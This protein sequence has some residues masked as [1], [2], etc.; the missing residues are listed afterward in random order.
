MAAGSKLAFGVFASSSLAGVLTLGVGPK[1]AHR[2]VRDAGPD[3]CLTLTR[4][5]LDDQLPRNAASRVLGLVIRAL[6]RHT[7]LRFVLSY[8]DPAAGH[9]GTVYQATGW[10]YTGLSEGTPLYDLG[11][12]IPRHSRSLGHAYGTRS[13]AYLHA[14]GIDV[15]LVAQ[16]R[17][18]RYLFPLHHS[19]RE[20]LTVP[21]LPYPKREAPDGDC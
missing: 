11:D 2:L 8:A 5:W 9:V 3:D 12:G 6:R 10:L 16:G 1:N 18:H 14:Q 7:S 20:R 17:K 21:I 19:A 4:L 15:R 13:L